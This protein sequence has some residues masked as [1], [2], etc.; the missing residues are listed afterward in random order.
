MPYADPAVQ[1]EYQRKWIARQRE[2]WF[3]L[4]G[5]CVDC[6]S[7]ESLQIDHV[8]NTQKVSHRIWSWSRKRREEELAKCVPR[9]Y[10]CHQK[11]S[12]TECHRGESASWSKLN[13][14]KV[15]EIRARAALGESKMGL[16]REYGVDRHT[17]YSIINPVTW[18]HI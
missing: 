4:N 18:K 14:E 13:N 10:P 9:C 16:G 11:K 3:S 2:E 15:R 8:D 7:S 12:A 17:I 6:G 1:R 5:Q